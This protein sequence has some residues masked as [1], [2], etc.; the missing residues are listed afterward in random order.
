MCFP[1]G[2]T[3][4]RKMIRWCPPVMWTLLYKAMN[5]IDISPTKT[6]SWNWSYVNPNWT[7][8]RLRGHHLVGYL[9]FLA[10]F[11]KTISTH[12]EKPSAISRIFCL[13]FT[14]HSARKSEVF[15]TWAEDHLAA[16]LPFTGTHQ[17]A[18]K[19]GLRW[20]SRAAPKWL[21]YPLVN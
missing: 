20:I 14:N 10:I 3:P 7:R 19:S 11:Q 15:G 2:E 8:S 13:P 9:F 4:L 5:T 1:W 18:W 17:A 21:F 6:S 12:S 16:L